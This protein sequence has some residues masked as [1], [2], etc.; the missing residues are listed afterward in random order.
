MFGSDG[1]LTN[2]IPPGQCGFL[3]SVCLTGDVCVHNVLQ[4]RRDLFF[5]DSALLQKGVPLGSS[6]VKVTAQGE[7][8]QVDQP[9]EQTRQCNYC[10]G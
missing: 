10:T 3:H 4:Q 2:F 1:L 9:R 5:T 8:R 7:T 6:R